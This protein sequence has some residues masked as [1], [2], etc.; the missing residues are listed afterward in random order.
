MNDIFLGI[1]LGTGNCSVAYVVDDPRQRDRRTIGVKTVPVPVDEEHDQLAERVPAVLA[2]D[3]DAD[4]GPPVF[5]WE[6][7]GRLRRKTRR[8]IPA[9]RRGVDLFYSVKSQIGTDRVY[10]FSRMEAVRTPVD[11]AAA[12]LAHLLA[13]V[14]RHN[15]L[16]DPAR[17]HVTITVPAS[18]SARARRETL[19]AARK[20]GLDLDRVELA[21]EPVAALVDLL[22][23]ETGAT[24][25]TA[26][27]QTL[28]VMDYGAG[29]CDLALVRARF[30]AEA[31]SGLEIENLALSPYARVG[32]DDVDRAVM[33]EIVWP[34]ICSPE[35]R[36]S[37]PEPVRRAVED[38]LTL[39]VARGL[40]EALCRRLQADLERGRDLRSTVAEYA[41]APSR[42]FALG[43]D[44]LKVP[45]QFRMNGAELEAIMRGFFRDPRA[46]SGAPAGQE[47]SPSI[48]AL[49]DET[50]ERG[51]LSRDRLDW[52]VLHGGAAKNPFVERLLQAALGPAGGRGGRVRVARTPNLLT[53]VARGAALIG[54][55]RHARGEDLVPPIMPEDLGIVAAGERAVP[56]VRAGQRLPYPADGGVVEIDEEF[57][58]P[59]S[60][61]EVM[62]VPYY[63]GR[64]D[65]PKVAGT[66]KVPLPDAVREG[67]PVRVKLRVDR[68]KG[69]HW[70]FSIDD[71]PFEPAGVV[72]DPW[73]SR[74]PN[75]HER[76]LLD[77]RRY[78]RERVEEGGEPAIDDLV[79]EA[80]LLRRVGGSR[81]LHEALEILDSLPPAAVAASAHNARGLVLWDLGRL[82]DAVAAFRRAA[83]AASPAAGAVYWGNYGCAL[84]ACGRRGEALAAIRRA[85]SLD[86]SRAYLHQRLADLH[87]E[88]GDEPSAQ[89]E[90]A[91]AIALLAAQ[92]EERPFNPDL[93]NELA[94]AHY[95][96]GDYEQAEQAWRRSEELERSALYEGDPSAVIARPVRAARPR[97]AGSRNE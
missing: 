80:M 35:D 28:L 61:P 10:P 88:E 29:T 81:E 87:R 12:M 57:R 7:Y 37:L 25:L 93:W 76:R 68:S 34:R 4:G 79:A 84:A 14:G 20:A 39:A 1:D 48:L 5:G 19:E 56:L 3:W 75:W 58:V 42:A 45:A 64:S 41:A 72:E 53:S 95:S 65:R 23:D 94:C 49:V 97:H 90:L 6:F 31:R 52:I 43:G 55:W 27:P 44:R 36:A 54:Y 73:T 71:G 26:A 67:A 46:G 40:K 22:N 38:T 60:R 21:D 8:P 50:L 62:L 18:F 77:H 78:V 33:R 24:V 51:G 91:R 59:D 86:A 63:T 30:D 2:V 47:E 16:L 32:G 89:R 66:V 85:L 74:A 82:E 13:A 83:E 17:A 70:W 69:L 11:A 92:I 96:A 9:M 15:R